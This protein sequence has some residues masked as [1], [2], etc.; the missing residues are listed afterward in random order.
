MEA[1][2]APTSPD[3]TVVAVG[4][5]L[6]FAILMLSWISVHPFQSMADEKLITVGDT[7][8]LVNQFAYVT[9]AAVAA[10][11]FLLLEPRQLRPLVRPVYFA[12]LAWLLVSVATSTDPALSLKRLIFVLLVIALAAVLPLLPTNLRRFADMT[13]A[14]A[15]VVLVLSYA[16]LLFAP[17]LSIHQADDLV[18]PTLA[19]NWRGVFSHKNI[20]GT[21]MV[22]FVFV[23]LFVARVRSMLLGAAIV[24]AS[25][26]FLFFCEAKAATELLPLVLVLSFALLRVRSWLVSAALVL[27]PTVALNL[28]TVGSLYSDRIR[29]FNQAVLSDPSFTG[30]NDIWQFALD[31]IH[32]GPWVG[33]GF[34]AFWETPLSFYQKAADGNL[35]MQASHAHNAF[36]DLALTIGL[37]GLVIGLA[38]TVLL[39]FLDLQRAK[40]AGAEVALTTLF[41]RIW[42]FGLYTSSFESVLF[43]RGNPTWFTMLVAMFGL[44]YLAVSRVKE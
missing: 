30:R 12:M 31:N 22:D 33:Y 44:R 36:I 18:E 15:G 42:L 20:A 17:E 19:G 21:M 26:V 41:T 32:A 28:V 8:D 29:E 39:P 14:A 3:A 27:A 2:R 11:Y 43:D 6:F 38:W 10:I 34:G 35:A 40:H 23:G 4:A 1:R 25:G 16:G 9:L 7:S 5:I 37:P 24:V 13:A